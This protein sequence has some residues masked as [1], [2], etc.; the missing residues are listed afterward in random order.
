[1]ELHNHIEEVNKLVEKIANEYAYMV[2]KNEE[3]EKR[4]FWLENNDA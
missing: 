4:I 1:M 2:K 3:L